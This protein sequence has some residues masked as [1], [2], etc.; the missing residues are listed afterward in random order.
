MNYPNF[1]RTVMAPIILD[2]LIGIN[3]LF[4]IWI[5]MGYIRIYILEQKLEAAET[6]HESSTWMNEQLHESTGDYQS[7]ILLWP[8][9]SLCSLWSRITSIKY[10]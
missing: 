8:I 9:N 4:L 6:L 7:K 5:F 10:T 1:A 2:N 3:A